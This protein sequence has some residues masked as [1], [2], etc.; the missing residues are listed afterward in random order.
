[1]LFFK[2]T[3]W[4]LSM[5]ASILLSISAPKN[6][7]GGQAIIEGVMM[8]GKEKVAWAV[9]RAN[10]GMVI[11]DQPFVSIC[12]PKTWYAL[13]IVR[14]AINLYESFKL[15]YKALARS[16]DIAAEDEQAAKA[17]QKT[18]EK[19]KKENSVKEKLF[20]AAN[21]LLA[22]GISIGLFM[23]APM[24]TVNRIEFIK[25]SPLLFNLSAGVIRIFLF[26]TYLAAISLWK[27]MRRVFEYHGA[28]H[29]AIF[30]YEDGKELTIDN[31]SSY[32][33]VHPRCGTSFLILVGISSILLFT[34]I[35]ALYIQYFG[36]FV[37]VAHRLGVHLLLIPLVSGFSYEV[38][39]LSDKYQRLP[40]V[41]LLIK[42]GLWLQKITTRAPDNTQLEVASTALKAAA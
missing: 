8:R 10:G 16:A 38:L 37:N 15:G 21:M 12:Q 14:G 22:L 20:F 39:K 31:M 19:P 2:Y 25:D 24:W 34:I 27:E 42:P 5:P 40:V 35:D 26:L 32:P 30:T 41:G 17:E 7:V 36:Q 33:T 28:E 3:L 11:E 4:F 29:M 9:R 23:Y 18:E 13:P 1:M 6:K